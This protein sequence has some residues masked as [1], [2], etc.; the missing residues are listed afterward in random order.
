MSILH[1]VVS[2]SNHKISPQLKSSVSQVLIDVANLFKPMVFSSCVSSE[3]IEP[4]TL[5][6]A[7][8]DLNLCISVARFAF[9]AEGG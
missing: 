7:L 2:E 9:S 4:Q 5:L 6:I 8:E 1:E 3:M